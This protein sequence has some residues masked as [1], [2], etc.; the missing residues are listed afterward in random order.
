M[1]PTPDVFNPQSVR[2]EMANLRLVQA[3]HPEN[4]EDSEIK[5]IAINDRRTA[6]E[7][8]VR[9]YR[10]RIYYHAYNVLKDHHEAFDVTQEVFIKAMREKRFFLPD[11]NMK[12]WL[13]RVTSNYCFNLVRDRKR[14]GGILE[15]MHKTEKTDADQLDLVFNSEQQEHI[16]EALEELTSDHRQILM[17]RYYDDLSYAEIAE[18]LQIKLGTV[19]SRLSRAKGRLLAVLEEQQTEL[20]A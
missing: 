19:M 18:V 6:V 20:T 2:R 3:R 12:A 11:F 4:I 14:R 9:K 17:L 8:V 15:R 1:S 13:F 16:F 5:A 7:L 10:E